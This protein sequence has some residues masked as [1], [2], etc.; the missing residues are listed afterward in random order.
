MVSV[1]IALYL[2]PVLG[3]GPWGLAAGELIFFAVIFAAS[4]FLYRWYER[5]ILRQRSRI[6]LCREAAVAQ[7]SRS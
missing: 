7:G 2:V 6:S 3:S 1:L 5:P 4:A